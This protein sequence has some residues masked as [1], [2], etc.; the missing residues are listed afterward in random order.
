MY[1]RRS[2]IHACIHIYVYST[3]LYIRIYVYTCVCVYVY[4]YTGIHAMYA[5]RSTMQSAV[6]MSDEG[7]SQRKNHPMYVCMHVCM[8]AHKCI[9]TTH[10]C[11]YTNMQTCFNTNF[12]YTNTLCVCLCVCVCVCN[13]LTTAQSYNVVAGTPPVPSAAIVA[14]QN[15]GRLCASQ[16][17]SALRE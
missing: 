17:P 9:Y 3:Y 5:R 15:G 1:A 2:T 16:A 8:F 11:I 13:I 4:V 12:L 14:A 10:K 6:A 7:A